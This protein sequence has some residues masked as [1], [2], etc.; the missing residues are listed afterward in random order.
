[1]KVLHVLAD[2][3]AD[4]GGLSGAVAQLAAALAARGIESPVMAG[5]LD[6]AALAG[7]ELVHIHG[8]WRPLL[9][10]AQAKA[11][12]MG[13]PV[14]LSPHGMLEPWSLRQKALKKRLALALVQGPLLRRARLHATSTDELEHLSELGYAA[15]LQPLGVALPPRPKTA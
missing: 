4:Q 2:A 13:L 11:L 10:R 8:L 9:W 7:V 3:G 15:E 1:M 5:P 6:E 14:V 12:R